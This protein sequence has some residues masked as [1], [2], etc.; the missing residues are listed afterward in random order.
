[1]SKTISF[2]GTLQIG[3]EQ[4]IDLKSLNALSSA[5]S[6]E[7]VRELYSV[8]FKLY[9]ISGFELKYFNIDIKWDTTKPMGDMK[10]LMSTKRAEKHGFKPEVSLEDG[11]IKTIKWY[12]EEFKL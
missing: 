9:G 10:R 11:I 5:V 7:T 8:Q 2:K 12:K 3:V 6:H 4:E 1:M